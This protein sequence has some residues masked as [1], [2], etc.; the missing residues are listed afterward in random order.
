MTVT[1]RVVVTMTVAVVMVMLVTVFVVMIVTVVVTMSVVVVMRRFVTMPVIVMMVVAFALG[2]IR[3]HAV[4]RTN[5]PLARDVELLH[6]GLKDRV[7]GRDDA[8][9][10]YECPLVHV[11][12]VVSR[13][14]PLHLSRRPDDEGVFRRELDGDHSVLVRE[15]H[16]AR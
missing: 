2:H 13:A 16:I 5:R 15:D 10:L 12:D 14:G 6:D 7:V 11:A 4:D 9:L 3:P 1:V 8:V